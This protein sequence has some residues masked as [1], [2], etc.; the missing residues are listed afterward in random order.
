MSLY[1][2][3]PANYCMVPRLSQMQ[4]A[5]ALNDERASRAKAFCT[6]K[7]RDTVRYTRDLM[8]D[9]CI[10]LEHLEHQ[11]ER[12]MANAEAIYSYEGTRGV[13]GDA[14]ADYRASDDRICRL[15]VD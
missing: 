3:W 4:D 15:R 2:S 6:S 10:L 14:F 9:N 13:M 1:R 11:V 5:G 12:F 7:C 8:A